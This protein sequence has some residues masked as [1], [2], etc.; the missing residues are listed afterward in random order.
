MS[1]SVIVPAYNAVEFLPET[2]E[3]VLRQ[4]H[5]VDEVLVIDDGSTDDT[6]AVAAAFGPPVRVMRTP[7]S[8]LSATRNFGVRH[9]TG[10]WIA[11]IDADD[12]W[13]DN[14]IERQMQELARHPE[15]GVCYSGR[16]LL[17][18]EGNTFRL[19]QETP[20]PPA[21]NIR[22]E[23]FRHVSFLPSSVIIRRSVYESVGGFDP[24][25]KNSEDYEMWLRLLH[26][27]VHFAGCPEPLFQYRRHGQNITASITPAMLEE[28]L[29]LYR[30]YIQPY[31]KGIA[32][33]LNYNRFRSPFEADVAYHLRSQNDPS[34][35]RMMAASLLHIPFGYSH[36]Y[37]VLAHMLLSR[38]K[39]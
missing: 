25:Q 8:K 7:N 13:N 31:Q 17:Y 28:Y 5:P 35:L 18:R 20:A 38:L 29:D 12:V 27:G 39:K 37:K 1:I 21:E 22:E 34:C 11:L 16:T 2:L 9:A 33:Q 23:L 10:E 26:A 32:G 6:S 15:A 36:R 14:K 30:R 19:G 24:K 3:S 4:T